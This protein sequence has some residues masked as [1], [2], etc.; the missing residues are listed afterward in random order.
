MHGEPIYICYMYVIRYNYRL[1]VF[2]RPGC[3]RCDARGVSAR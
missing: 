3:D 2:Q 1:Y